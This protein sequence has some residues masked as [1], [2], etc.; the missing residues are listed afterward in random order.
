[1]GYRPLWQVSQTLDMPQYTS[2]TLCDRTNANTLDH[3]CLQCP[4]VRDVLPRDGRIDLHS[5]KSCFG[6]TCVDSSLKESSRALQKSDIDVGQI[7]DTD[8]GRGRLLARGD[9]NIHNTPISANEEF[10]RTAGHDKEEETLD[11]FHE[12]KTEGVAL[13]PK[14][15]PEEVLVTSDQDMELDVETSTPRTD[16]KEEEEEDVGGEVYDST[17]REPEI[18]DALTETGIIMST[19]G[20]TKSSDNVEVSTQN[21]FE[22]TNTEAYAEETEIREGDNIPK[23]NSSFQG[24]FSEDVDDFLEIFE[25]DQNVTEKRNRV[26]NKK[27]F[28]KNVTPRRDIWIQDI[29]K[30]IKREKNRGRNRKN[31]FKKIKK[32]KLRNRIKNHVTET[33]H[34]ESFKEDIEVFNTTAVEVNIQRLANFTP[35]EPRQHEVIFVED[36]VHIIEDPSDTELV[37]TVSLWEYLMNYMTGDE[38]EIPEKTMVIEKRLEHPCDHLPGD[39]GSWTHRAQPTRVIVMGGGVAGLSALRTLNKLGLTDAV[40]IEASSRLGGRLHTVRHAEWMVEEGAPTIQGEALNPLYQLAYELNALGFPVLD[41][42]WEDDVVTSDGGMQLPPIIEKGRR[43]FHQLQNDPRERAALKSFGDK[44]LGDLLATRFDDMWGTTKDDKDKQAWMYY[45]HQKVSKKFG[46]NSW[47]NV[48]AKDAANF[49]DLGREYTWSGGMDGLIQ[50]LLHEVSANQLRLSSPVCQVFWNI[51]SDDG[52]TLVVLADGTSYRARYVISALPVGVLKERHFAT[53]FPPLPRQLTKALKAVDPG[54]VDRI[55]LGWPYSWWGPKPFNQQV[56]WREY[57]FPHEMEWMSNIVEIRSA[58]HQPTQLE[59]EVFGDA[60]AAMEN[61]DPETLIAHLVTFLRTTNRQY[62]VNLPTFF[63]R[64]KWHQNKWTQGSYQSYMNMDAVDLDVNDRSELRPDLTNS[65]GQRTLF[66]SGEHTSSDRFGTVDGA[67]LSGVRAARWVMDDH[68]KF[69]KLYVVSDGER[70]RLRPLNDQKVKIDY[71]QYFKNPAVAYQAAAILADEKVQRVSSKEEQ[72]ERISKVEEKKA[73]RKAAKEARQA[74]KE[75]RQAERRKKKRGQKDSKEREEKQPLDVQIRA[76]DGLE[77]RS[78]LAEPRYNGP[79]S[80]MHTYSDHYPSSNEGQIIA[81]HPAG[82]L[83]PESPYHSIMPMSSERFGP[84][85][86]NPEPEVAVVYVDP[87][88]NPIDFP[89]YDYSHPVGYESSDEITVYYVDPSSN[90]EP[91]IGAPSSI[92]YAANPVKTR[93]HSA[94]IPPRKSV[95]LPSQVPPNSPHGTNNG[96]NRSDNNDNEPNRESSSSKSSETVRTSKES[97]SETQSIQDEVA[98]LA[99]EPP[100]EGNRASQSTLMHKSKPWMHTTSNLAPQPQNSGQVYSPYHTS[101]SSTVQVPSINQQADLSNTMNHQNLYPQSTN[102]HYPPVYNYNAGNPQQVNSHVYHP[103]FPSGNPS[104]TLHSQSSGNSGSV[105]NSYTSVPVSDPGNNHDLPSKLGVS[106]QEQ[107]DQGI[108]GQDAIGSGLELA[109][110]ISIDDA[111]AKRHK[112]DEEI[113]SQSQNKSDKPEPQRSNKRRP[114]NGN[115]KH[116]EIEKNRG[117]NKYKNRFNRPKSRVGHN[118]RFRPN[119]YR[120][121]MYSPLER[122]R[123]SMMEDEPYIIVPQSH[124]YPRNQYDHGLRKRGREQEDSIYEQRGIKDDDQIMIEDT[125]ANQN[126]TTDSEEIQ[127]AVIYN[128]TDNTTVDIVDLTSDSAIPVTENKIAVYDNNATVLEVT[129]VDAVSLQPIPSQR[130]E[131]STSHLVHNLPPNSDKTLQTPTVQSVSGIPALSPIPFLYPIPYIGQFMQGIGSVFGNPNAL[132]GVTLNENNVQNPEGPQ[133]A[134]LS[135]PSSPQDSAP[136]E[137]KK[138]THNLEE[139]SSQQPTRETSRTEDNLMSS[140]NKKSKNNSRRGGSRKGSNRKRRPSSRESKVVEGL[141][142]EKTDINPQL[143]TL[144][145]PLSELEGRT[146]PSHID[147]AHEVFEDQTSV[148]ATSESLA[149]IPNASDEFLFETIITQNKSDYFLQR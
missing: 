139:T 141:D 83:M 102:L 90:E 45:I 89:S 91:D 42:D 51:P 111:I 92:M 76:K 79:Q 33:G 113:E 104:M 106:T 65:R 115:R 148:H 23:T 55:A 140:A 53:F 50:Y 109:L 70:R 100:K 132:T 10:E 128:I 8:L 107:N 143:L 20:Y 16:Q 101:S 30:I 149:A 86:I 136:Q 87:E 52:S 94:I 26:K 4:A 2:C 14:E 32:D 124:L 74:A 15:N 40:L 71:F 22:E 96:S 127:T 135:S 43:I 56:L 64:S 41:I 60:A 29:V 146:D 11:S 117:K 95:A 57:N 78:R 6:N 118:P 93:T 97:S 108:R 85:H 63:H 21:Y 84:V 103:S 144:R 61:M 7:S 120:P 88:G 5:H 125:S 82:H 58:P 121:V 75:A 72:G 80:Q 99:P 81:V 47:M 69:E 129:T 137:E 123:Y 112:K 1:M 54:L 25:V 44:A 19:V 133:R 130:D 67:L 122:H 66:F 34:E 39:Y 37:S 68:A 116:P 98:Y 27:K 138:I 73:A 46:V 48:A 105:P 114:N 62:T 38:P 145:Q 17:E 147:Q 119:V 9:E 36:G 131:A 31:R 110:P 13:G 12:H 3:Y 134:K 77:K 24:S 18:Y 35:R 126:S 49:V 59:M 142:H 28:R